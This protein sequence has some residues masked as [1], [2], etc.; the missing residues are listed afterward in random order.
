MFSSF[1]I[2][3]HVICHNYDPIQW[4]APFRSKRRLY[5]IMR[6]GR[7]ALVRRRLPISATRFLDYLR[8]PAASLLDQLGVP[9]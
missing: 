4:L 7:E 2:D 6:L 5:S 1:M 9:A 3:L 8:Q